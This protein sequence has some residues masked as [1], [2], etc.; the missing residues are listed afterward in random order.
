MADVALPGRRLTSFG[1]VGCIEDAPAFR[2][3]QK[4]PPS[5]GAQGAATLLASA[6]QHSARLIAA[7][8]QPAG[9]RPSLSGALLQRFEREGLAGFSSFPVGTGQCC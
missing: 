5:L 9:C 7:W 4:A 8:A 6:E 2:P 3:A 1:V